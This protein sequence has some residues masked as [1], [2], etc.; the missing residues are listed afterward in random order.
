MIAKDKVKHLIETQGRFVEG[1][2]FQECNKFEI[3]IIARLSEINSLAI[4]L[5]LVN[6]KNQSPKF[7]ILE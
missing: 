4:P 1:N 2:I 6:R 3:N 7:A 5:Q